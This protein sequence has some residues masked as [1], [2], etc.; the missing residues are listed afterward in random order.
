MP[1]RPAGAR[2]TV[3]QLAAADSAEKWSG[4]MET[5]DGPVPIYLTL[6]RQPSDQARQHA[7]AVTG[8]LATAVES[9]TVPI[10]KGEIQGDKLTFEIH[11]KAGEIV[12]F[13]SR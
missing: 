4:T 1:P 9:E 12:T 8:T 7:E 5:S 3:C 13:Q 2:C 6:N 11:D 10:E